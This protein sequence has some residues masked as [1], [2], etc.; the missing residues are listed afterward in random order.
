MRALSTIFLTSLPLL[1]FAGT[2]PAQWVQTN[3][4]YVDRIVTSLAVSGTNLFAG[5]YSDAL[6][7]VSGAC[8]STDDG[9]SWTSVDS[10]KSGAVMALAVSGTNLFA[11]NGSGVYLSTNNGTS[12]TLVDSGLTNQ[13][14]WS[15]AVS[16]TN[17]WAGTSGGGVFL[18]TNNGT[19]WTA[20]N[21]GVPISGSE[22]TSL[23]VSGTNLFAGTWGDGV[24]H[25][26]N[27]GTNWTL[28][29]SGLTGNYFHFLAFYDTNIF[30]GT[31][32]GIYR[33][34]NSRS[35]WIA[36][37]SGL[38]NSIVYSFAVGGTSLFA[39]TRGGGVF[40]SSNNG[41]SWTAVNNGLTNPDVTALAVSGSNLFAGI[42]SNA[43]VF[44]GSV[45]RRPLSEMITSTKSSSSELPVAFQLNQNY[46]NP[47]NP[48][49]TISYQLPNQAHVTLKVF[50][51]LGREVATLVNKLEEPGYKSVVFDGG[52]LAT[53]V[54][55]YRLQVGT[56]IATK[57]LLLLR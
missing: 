49:T 44:N 47:F 2:V 51:V 7:A 11:G 6:H 50:D 35:S 28:V 18:S 30:A 1:L 46:P 16:G 27:N 57:R 20:V 24:F 14:V 40:L 37:D 3:F 53:G 52:R 5:T 17:L 25:L 29:D 21:N 10:G 36:V 15:L 31:Y 48:S 39:G 45:W 41:T 19:S 38:T 12:W 55:N 56:Y 9:T 23:A 8:L 4:P 54:Y 33:S 13:S 34:A 42:N 32:S 43:G 22:V 26:T